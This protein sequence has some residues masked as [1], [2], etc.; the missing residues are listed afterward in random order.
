MK[1]LSFW[2]AIPL[3]CIL[4]S[5]SGRNNESGNINVNLLRCENRINPLGIDISQPRLS[6]IS[7]S[8]IRDQKQSAY[9]ILV[10][11]SEK[12]L[13]S[14]QGDLWD[15]K[16]IS[17]DQSINIPYAGSA[18]KSGSYCYWK[19][20]IWDANQKE[21]EWSKV[22]YWSMGLL[23]PEE[24]KAQWIGYEQKIA[25][26]RFKSEER[27]L[28]ARMLRKEFQINKKIKKATAY[29]SGLGLFELYINGSKIGDQVLA[30]PL[31][32]YSVRTYYM[33]FDVSK[34]IKKDKNAVG[35]ILGN[36][37]YYAP[38]LSVPMT[39]A[40]YGFPKMIF[41]MT[42]EFE[43]GSIETIT[44]DETWKVTDKGPIMANN[45]FDGE[46]YDA[47]KE[48]TGW[49]N[50]GFI[51]KN[52]NPAELVQKPS[53]VLTALSQE[54]IK[55]TGTI[56]P[57]KVFRRKTGE[58]IYDMGQNMVGW[59]SIKI[60]GA[61]RNTII[62]MRFAETLKADSS[63]YM[64]NLRSAKVT[65]FY[66]ANGTEN[67]WWS[68]RFTY[69]G[70]RYVELTGY[71][72]I[73]DLNTI[74][75]QVVHD[76][77]MTTGEFSCSN[78]IINKIY[79]NAIWGIRGNYRS[80]PTDCPQRDERQGWLG[81]RAM[82]SLGESYI[83]DIHNLY[84]KWLLDIGD[85]Q[86]EAG[87][88]PDVAPT[89]WEIYNDNTT[90]AGAFIIAA[91]WLYFQY[92]DE[93]LIQ[94]L[95]PKMKKWYIYMQKYIDNRGLMTKDTYGDW[96]MP[97]ES[98]DLIHS[99]DP[100]RITPSDLIGTSYFYY[101]SNI[102][103][104]F[105]KITKNST[106]E[107]FFE[108]SAI[109][110]KSA[111]NQYLYSA[112]LNYYGNNSST[113]NLLALALNMVPETEKEKVFESFL[114]KLE[115]TDR[116]HINVGLVGAQWLMKTLT[117]FGYEE[118]AL[119]LASNT[120]YPSWG[121]MV[122]NNA[123]TIWELWNGN[124]AD[125]AM[126]SGNHVMLLG[127]L[128]PWFYQY[129]GGIRPDWE[130]PAYKKFILKPVIPQGLFECKTYFMSEY[131]QI[132]SHWTLNK[133]T[134]T[135]SWNI[136]VPFNTNAMVYVPSTEKSIVSESKKDAKKVN[137]LKFL[138]FENGYN[139]FEAASGDYSFEISEY[140]TNK[141]GKPYTRTPKFNIE[142]K[143]AKK[144]EKIKISL[145]TDEPDAIIRF[146]T[147]GSQVTE[148][149]PVYQNEIM[150]E[151]YSSLKAQ[152]FKDGYKPSGIAICL[153]DFI[154]EKVNG[155]NYSLYEG[156]WKNL[157][158]FSKLNA[159]KTGK[160]PDLLLKNVKIKEDFWGVVFEGYINLPISGSFTFSTSSDDGS[161]IFIDD[162]SVVINDGIHGIAQR[163]GIVELT[164]GKH[165]IRIEF[166]DGNM[167]DEL[168]VY[169]RHK[170]IPFQLLPISWLCFE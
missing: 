138:R 51:D 73:P 94:N 144:G 52:W 77:I 18:L 65:D 68:P 57:I 131:G 53:P 81:D 38:R 111:F 147:D 6:W 102:M 142:N 169:V 137:G 87:S 23:K 123:T 26:D 116:G 9:Q 107:N 42:C 132:K 64:E 2:I 78:E 150:I 163:D 41:Q 99:K 50:P 139:I 112:D 134:K 129:L 148:N 160:T 14:N 90:W 24:W 19:V 74:I 135:L 48:M 11:S 56:K 33:T 143:V 91:Q 124:T 30:P 60:Q 153:I 126:N 92:G 113:S 106:D 66:T 141:K 13:A 67:T 46:E 21:S 125:P 55:I 154:D 97:P 45:E 104:S 63:L 89:F 130:N 157:P 167:G 120:T 170:L 158:D 31:S 136:A 86:N 168:K 156:E 15:S 133:D 149:S 98:L 145:S 165:K 84:A 28:A 80:M 93:R 54:P 122:K 117:E 95:Y 7:E 3:L 49:N 40:S 119:K 71:P 37:R 118:E 109:K 159:V 152:A 44:S 162:K 146:S 17:S 12:I 32:Q 96:C 16:K 62:K 25:A 47:N 36:G 114:S 101:L 58:Y 27:G 127:D 110:L 34:F 128:I 75:G 20:K 72:G 59:C 151:K 88:I 82:G 100:S 39:T 83:F 105:A 108:Q 164:Q 35:V 10:A 85:A 5:F 140:Q 4:F 22:A 121:Y 79:Q 8:K 70:F 61:E 115:G 69:H 29:I 76:D 161:Q 166:F 103:K 155:L 43:D 1:K